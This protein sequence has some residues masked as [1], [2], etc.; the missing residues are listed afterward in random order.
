MSNVL[1]PGLFLL[2]NSYNE[3]SL[4]K[5][6]LITKFMTLI[7]VFQGKNCALLASDL[8][9]R[10]AEESQVTSPPSRQNY[11]TFISEKFRELPNGDYL[12]IN[13]RL[14]SQE[15]SCIVS[16]S[17]QELKTTLLARDPLIRNDQE[18]MILYASI[19]DARVYAAR[20]TH[21]LLAAQRGQP[22]AACDRIEYASSLMEIT[23]R[24]REGKKWDKEFLRELSA[25]YERYF[26]NAE[27]ST[28]CFGGYVSYLVSPGKIR[29]ITKN[30]GKLK[31]CLEARM[32][33][34]G[35]VFY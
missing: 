25:Q 8:Q 3:K 13:G 10:F 7:T 6:R 35:S 23:A 12:G 21:P 15:Y 22:F 28:D 24:L 30:P 5:G 4:K 20:S 29:R 16:K 1:N 14:S 34:N 19:S 31:D 33:L 18:L 9:L 2:K 27:K 11:R 17:F 26:L 32:G